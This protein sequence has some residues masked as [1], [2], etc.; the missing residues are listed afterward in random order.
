LEGIVHAHLKIIA[1]NYLK[2]KVTDLVATEV[3]F[4]N[5][6]SIADAVGLNLKRR[7]VRVIEVKATN[8]DFIRD[9]KLFGAK[10]SYF[11]HAH[12]SYIMCPT[13]VIK[14]TDLPHGYGLLYVNDRDEIEIAKKPLKNTGRLK[15]LF[16]TTTYTDNIPT[17]KKYL[18]EFKDLIQGRQHQKQYDALY[19]NLTKNN[20]PTPII[21]LP[22]TAVNRSY[23]AEYQ[24]KI[25]RQSHQR[26]YDALSK[27][28]TT[29]KISNDIF[30]TPSQEEKRPTGNTPQIKP[31]RQSLPNLNG[32]VGNSSIDS[33]LDKP[34]DKGIGI[35]M[36]TVN[37]IT[38]S[39]QMARVLSPNM[40]TII[41]YNMTNQMK[42]L[43]FPPARELSKIIRKPV[44][45]AKGKIEPVPTSPIKYKLKS[46]RTPKA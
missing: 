21:Q 45:N 8:A 42:E 10:T 26:Q 2:T 32:N 13:G 29:K 12:Y 24:E 23:A 15:T 44:K 9:K 40:N 35:G 22:N 1:V 38:F 14:P 25:K 28:L 43:D 27:N 7:E 34:V 33:P 30:L 36:R 31:R 11:V 46:T 41:K 18:D 17:N 3:K 5:A 6:Y 20:I 19:K 16:D 37:G 4:I 39:N